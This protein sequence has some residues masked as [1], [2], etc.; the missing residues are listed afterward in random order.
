MKADQLFDEGQSN[1]QSPRARYR[2]RPTGR[3]ARDPGQVGHRDAAA[4]IANRDDGSILDPLQAHSHLAAPAAELGRVVDEVRRHLRQSDRVG[5]GLHGP[6]GSVTTRSAPCASIAAWPSSIA[7]ERP[8]AN[9]WWRTGAQSSCVKRERPADPR[10]GGTGAPAA[11]NRSCTPVTVAS[12]TGR[13][14][15]QSAATTSDDQRRAQ[16]VRQ[17]GEELVFHPVDPLVLRFAGCDF[18]AFSLDPRAHRSS[19]GG[20]SAL[21]K[22]IDEYRNLRT[23]DIRVE[24]LD[25]ESTAPAA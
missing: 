18:S 23:Q 17:R 4:P 12:C 1:T 21:A 13:R 16:L 3:R 11:A 7:P 10:P 20:L 25:H 8:R 24:R 2:W 14:S 6:G 9:R 19:G 15:R 22:Q 5:V